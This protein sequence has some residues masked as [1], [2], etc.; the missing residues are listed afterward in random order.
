VTRCA[1]VRHELVEG[2]EQPALSEQNEAVETLVPDRAHE[3]LRVGVGIRR[4]DRRQHDP[5]PGALDDAAECVRPL[6][7]SIAD[8]HP[9]AGQG[10]HQ[11]RR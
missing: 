11:P 1:V 3:A 7:V 2:A 4:L 5:H 10:T 8:E 6:A 9:V